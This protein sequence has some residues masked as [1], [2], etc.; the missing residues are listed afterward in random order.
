[1]GFSLF[2]A[3]YDH[4][5][6]TKLAYQEDNEHIELLLRQHWFTNLGWI[7]TVLIIIFLPFLF[8]LANPYVQSFGIN[9]PPDIELSLI[10]LWYLF[11]LAYVIERF[12][13]WYFNVNIVTNSHIIDIDFQNLMNR[14][15]TEVRLE[16]IQ[17]PRARIKGVMGSLFN[18][19][20]V[21]IETA[22]KTQF[23]DFAS[24]PNP[25]FVVDRIQDLQEEIARRKGGVPTSGHDLNAG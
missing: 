24:V 8:P 1:M 19:G 21:K 20:D 10:V 15:T 6:N 7:L 11:V 9:V 5:T 18:F 16:D 17:S 14:Y 2:P 25:D 22:A 23:V 3:F 4:P 12:F 13:S